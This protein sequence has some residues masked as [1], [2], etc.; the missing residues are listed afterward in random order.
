M[1]KF[2]NVFA[3]ILFTA[4]VFAQSPQKMSYQAVIRDGSGVLVSNHLV[5][6]QISILQ[7][8]PTG[9]VV[10]VETQTLT[11]NAN[12]LAT[13][14][15]GGGAGF[16][17]IDWATGPY[18]IKTETD[19][20]GGTTYTITGTSQLLSVP[21][22]LYSANGTPGPTGPTGPAGPA[23]ATGATGPAGADGAIGATGPAG[24][25]GA[26][27]ATGATGATGADGAVG[28]TGA[29]GATGADGAVGATGA[30]GPLVAGTIGQTLRHDGTSWVANSII[31]N[32]GTNVGINS[33]GATPNPKAMLDINATSGGLFIPRM[34]T[35]Q[36][37]AL[38]PGASENSLLIFNTTTECFEA[39]YASS[40][41]WIAFGC[42]GC[43]P[44]TANAGTDINPACGVTTATLAGNT[45]TVGTGAWSVV[46]G[47]ATITTPTSPTSGVTGLAVPGTATL[48]WTIS[49]PPC[50]PSFDDVI[51]TTTACFTCGGTL[52][53]NHTIGDVAPE[54]KSVNYGTV[55]T[56]LGGTGDKCWLTQNLGSTNQAS[57]AT[58]ATDAAA[59]W[60]WQFNRKQGYKVG[61]TPTWTITS[62]SETSD[63][64][65]AQD[66]CTI[67]LGAGW[68]IP[69][70]TEWYNA[71]ATGA[72]NNYTDT[73]NSVL[74]IHAAG[75]LNYYN[76][77]LSDRGTFGNY[78]SSTQDFATNG[79]YFFFFSSNSYM[80]S[81]RKACGIS[82]RCLR[83]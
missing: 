12:G 42:I 52:A 55:S 6:M 54:T 47:T 13:L 7:G 66:P 2:I 8:S 57:S 39:W 40:S 59:G 51:I 73:Y 27:G 68:R 48:C 41:T 44:T 63:W 11:T 50:T 58:D 56:T 32:N 14:E 34:T 76:G 15:I 77:S 71:D 79:W 5:G 36:R 37:D 33:T 53:I 80:V 28:A 74:K 22:A 25:D 75:Y 65:A 61:P 45:P 38:S 10:Y 9:T 49:N 16:S 26:I 30:T 78:W 83:D 69:T 70:N 19:P 18:Y 29:T 1:K 46:S 20:T 82:L 67:E 60:Y 3:A 24:A 21:Y 72:W 17:T 64:V 23:G 35:P 81:F 31:Y 62:I 43:T 4:S